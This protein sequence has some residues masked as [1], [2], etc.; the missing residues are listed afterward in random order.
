MRSFRRDFVGTLQRVIKALERLNDEEFAKLTD[1]KYEVEIKLV[2]KHQREEVNTKT[3]LEIESLVSH[4]TGFSS[5]EEALIFLSSSYKTRKIL[6]Q[7]ARWLDIPILSNDKVETLSEKI[8][9][10]TTGARIRSQAIKGES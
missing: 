6:E 4:L 3:I 5:R 2:R 9:E 1:D 10:S 8:I 7:I